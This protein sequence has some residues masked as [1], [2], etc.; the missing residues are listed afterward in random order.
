LTPDA[1]MAARDGGFV[2]T[3]RSCVDLLVAERDRALDDRL[4]RISS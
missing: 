3:H 4:E 2:L 1:V